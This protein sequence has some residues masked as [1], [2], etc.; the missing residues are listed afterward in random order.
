MLKPFIIL[1]LV[2]IVASAIKAQS[3]EALLQQAVANNPQLKALQLD[4][5]AALQKAPQV[6]H[7]PN[8]QAGIGAPILR[9]ETRLGP[10][11]LMIS[12]NQVFP[13]F[14]TLQAKEDVVLTM[15]KSKYEK[16]TAIRL[17]LFYTIKSAYYQLY[18]LDGQ[19]A[20]LKKHIQ[21][22]QTLER[23]TLGKVESGK[24]NTADVLRIRLKLQGLQQQLNIL[25]NQKQPL[26]AQINAVIN[27]SST[28]TIHLTEPLDSIAILN[29]DLPAYQAKIQAFHPLIKQLDWQLEASKSEQQ[30]NTL[31]GKPSLGVGLDYQLVA[32]RS[33]ATPINNGRDILIPKITMSVPIYRKQYVAK[34]EEERLKQAAIAYQKTAIENRILSHLQRYKTDYDNALLIIELKNQQINTTQAAYRILLGE[35]SSKG[36][37]FD[38]LMQFQNDLI[39]YDLEI[40]KAIVQTHLSKANI[41]RLADY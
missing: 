39:N 40:L 25:E 2:L 23:T 26:Y 12:A 15:A 5:E 41:E 18:L 36:T 28:D 14:G 20:L 7:L 17:D 6:R 35:Y 22:F 31:M 32:P 37:R 13:W 29:Y 19:Q 34:D 27:Q 33:D 24:A 8:P 4:Y 21:L 9:P 1:G 11:L 30:L 10:Q 38:E 3:I 16:I